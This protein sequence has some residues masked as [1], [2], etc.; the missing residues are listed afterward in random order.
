M[1]P[2]GER[3]RPVLRIA[4]RAGALGAFS[5][6]AKAAATTPVAYS[7]PA[8]VTDSTMT[9]VTGTFSWWPTVFVATA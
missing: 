7:P 2:P 4:R 5:P 8:R 9:G 3:S 1:A 6:A